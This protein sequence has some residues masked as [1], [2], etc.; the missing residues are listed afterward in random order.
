VSEADPLLAECPAHVPPECV[1]DFDYFNP[2]GMEKGED[3][4][5]ALGHLHE[6]SDLVW[7][8]RNG[9]CRCRSPQ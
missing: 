1:V 8:P 5:T 4:F 6:G 3:V 2:P 9:V 7:T